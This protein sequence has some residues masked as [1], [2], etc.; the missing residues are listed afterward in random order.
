MLPLRLLALAWIA[1]PTSAIAQDLVDLSFRLGDCAQ[2]GDIVRLDLIATSQTTSTSAVAAIDAILD[3]DPLAIE[4][5]DSDNAS[6]GH[7]WLLT[8]F[9]P[10]PDG[11]NASTMDGDALFTALTSPSLPAVIPPAPGIVVTT[12]LFRLL[13]PAPL[14]SVVSMTPTL[15]TFGSTDVYSFAS[16]GTSITGDISSEGRLFTCPYGASF[17]GAAIPNSTGQAGRIQA[18][19]T[20]VV[21]QNSFTLAVS[22]LP[23]N[24]FGFVLASRLQ[25]FRPSIAGSQGI[26]CLGDPIGRGVGNV[27]FN[28]S[29]TG[30]ATVLANLTQMP[31]PMGNV[32]VLPGETWNFQCW[33]RDINPVQTSNFTDAI[34]V[35]FY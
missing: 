1:S 29:T 10:D 13:A 19:G 22:Q 7:P 31:Q 11:I 23:L 5:V 33:H 2:V 12:F 14:G 30:T 8:G 21:A 28:T 20:P 16:P 9:L 18:I 34:E 32:A 35:T 25:D 27:I 15:G 26:L 6:A 17:C 3:W 4:L 24:S